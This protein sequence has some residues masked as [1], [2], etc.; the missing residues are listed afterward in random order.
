MLVVTSL[1]LLA[2]T[3]SVSL[4]AGIAVTTL[5]YV[6]GVVALAENVISQLLF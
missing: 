1:R 4:P 2:G 6:P 3:V 5:T